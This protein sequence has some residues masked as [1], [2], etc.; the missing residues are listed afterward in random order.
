[1]FHANMIAREMVLSAGFNRKLG[2]VSLM[3]VRGGGG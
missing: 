1:M 2:P 3:Q